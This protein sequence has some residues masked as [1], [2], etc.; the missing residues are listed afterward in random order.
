MLDLEVL[1][2]L[3]EFKV[4][5]TETLTTLFYKNKKYAQR[6]LLKLYKE[7]EV[8]RERDHINQQYRYWIKGSKPK[9][10]KH[11]ILR[12]RFHAKLSDIVKIE[13]FK[14][15]FK[16][17]NIIPDGFLVFKKNGYFYS[18]FIE[19][20][21]SPNS[22]IDKYKHLFHSKLWQKRFNGVFP[23]VVFITNQS[24]DDEQDFTLI[25]VKE[26]LT[27]IHRIL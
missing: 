6:R 3:Q 22:D 14:P 8:D 19:I 20:Q 1:Q 7:R 16:L 12:T 25:Q 4:V 5:D 13:F 27:D 21:L 9:Q 23:R 10:M 2:Y 15:A 17:F 26:D 11:S 24:M 18:N